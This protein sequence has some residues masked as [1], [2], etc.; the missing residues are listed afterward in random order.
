MFASSFVIPYLYN[1][2]DV[3][4][5]VSTTFLR[6]MSVLFWVYMANTTCYF[7]MR[8]GGDT[9]NTFFMDSFYMWTINIPI[10]ACIA[11]LTDYSIIVLYL[12]GQSTDIIKLLIA[13]RMVKKE[14]WVKNL[15]VN[16]DE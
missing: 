1:I 8:A 4:I 6:I 11:Y 13:L 2:S 16:H 14:R 12:A 7:V 15:T 5:S 10:V 9:T 3:S